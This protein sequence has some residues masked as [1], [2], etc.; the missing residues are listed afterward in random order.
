MVAGIKRIGKAYS[1][2]T[3]KNRVDIR[4]GGQSLIWIYQENYGIMKYD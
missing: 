4:I 3:I 1:E 2:I